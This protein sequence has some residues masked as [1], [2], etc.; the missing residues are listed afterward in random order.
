[1]YIIDPNNVNNILVINPN[2]QS[3]H[4][5]VGEKDI[6]IINKGMFVRNN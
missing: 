3:L 6:P 1:M 4:Q 2:T 5:M